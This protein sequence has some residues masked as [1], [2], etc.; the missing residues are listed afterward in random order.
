M[1]RAFGAQGADGRLLADDQHI[2]VSAG[3]AALPGAKPDPGHE[4]AKMIC[5]S[6]LITRR[7]FCEGRQ[8][9]CRGGALGNLARTDMRLAR[10][11]KRPDLNQ[12]QIGFDQFRAQRGIEVE[13]RHTGGPAAPQPGAPAQ[14]KRLDRTRLGAFMEQFDACGIVGAFQCFCDNEPEDRAAPRRRPWHAIRRHDLRDPGA[15]LGG[16]HAGKQPGIPKAATLEGS[17]YLA[18]FN[19]QAGRRQEPMAQDAWLQHMKRLPELHAGRHKIGGIGDVELVLAVVACGRAA[20]RFQPVKRELRLA[21]EPPE[22]GLP[23]A[24]VNDEKSNG[25]D[26]LGLH[27]EEAVMGADDDVG[28]HRQRLLALIAAL[29]VKWTKQRDAILPELAAA[30]LHGMFDL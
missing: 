6:F 20:D 4:I 16:V 10:G 3:P 9:F 27:V 26:R 13:D 8:G 21:I 5:G 18:L 30:L 15:A 7:G 11:Y 28:F 2:H 23:E 19:G 22:T 1:K 29:A 25:A 12:G 24:L 17:G 14:A